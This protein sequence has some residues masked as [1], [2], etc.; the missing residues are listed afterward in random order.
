MAEWTRN[1]PEEDGVY[2]VLLKDGEHTFS[3]YPV[4]LY[5][6][7]FV[8]CDEDLAWASPRDLVD[9]CW[10]M[11]VELPDMPTEESEDE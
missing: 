6:G 8:D 7:L 2:V 5:E 9:P 11:K 1:L 3:I 4:V 10:F